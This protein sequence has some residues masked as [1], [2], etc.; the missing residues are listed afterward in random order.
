MLAGVGYHVTI[1]KGSDSELVT[2]DV[3]KIVTETIPNASILSNVSSEI[4]FRLPLDAAD[5]FPEMFIELDKKIDEG[6]VSTYGVGITTLDEVFLQVARGESLE[7]SPQASSRVLVADNR[8]DHNHS[9]SDRSG[10]DRLNSSSYRSQEDISDPALFAGH[11]RSLFAKRAMY[12]KR[13]KKAWACSTFL[14][15]LFSFFGFINVTMLAPS[16]LMQPLELKTSDYNDISGGKIAF[17]INEPENFVCEPAKC[18]GALAGNYY[19]DDSYCGNDLLLNNTAEQCSAVTIDNF[20]D[21]LDSTNY[22][23]I[24]QNVSNIMEV[25]NIFSGYNLATKNDAIIHYSLF[26]T[27]FKT[28]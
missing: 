21:G 14:P 7:K 3:K 10:S 27:G 16:R 5:R 15:V 12:F 20:S 8:N 6:I 2:A 9:S 11:V 26:A 25:R 1:E 19:D 18:L 28:N 24:S 23:P 22:I 13:D 17:P 4:T